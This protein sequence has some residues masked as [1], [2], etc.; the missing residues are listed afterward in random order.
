M[1]SVKR[2]QTLRDTLRH[3]IVAA[4]WASDTIAVKLRAKRKSFNS[5]SERTKA[6]PLK[7]TDGNT[8]IGNGLFGVFGLSRA[9]RL[10]CAGKVHRETGAMDTAG[11]NGPW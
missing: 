3:R 7:A 5:L 6:T 1:C 9:A 10:A 8:A 11:G 2:Q 4:A